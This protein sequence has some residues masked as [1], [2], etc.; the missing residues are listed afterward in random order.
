MF[1]KCLVILLK[2]STFSKQWIQAWN[3]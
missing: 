1:V 3:S 2:M